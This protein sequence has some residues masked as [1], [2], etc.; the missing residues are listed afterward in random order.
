M[1]LYPRYILLFVI[2]IEGAFETVAN[3]FPF[4]KILIVFPFFPT[5]KR[6]GVFN[7]MTNWA[8]LT[9]NDPYDDT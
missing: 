2:S 5:V 4:T 7:E 8:V 9:T 3:G 6:Y 1:K